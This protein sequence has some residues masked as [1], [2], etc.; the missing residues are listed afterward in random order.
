M[1]NF[2]CLTYQTHYQGFVISVYPWGDE[3]IFYAK[4]GDG[5]VKHEGAP[6]K[7]YDTVDGA[8]NV[9]KD[10]IDFIYGDVDCYQ[11]RPLGAQDASAT[12]LIPQ[13][14]AVTVRLSYL[15]EPRAI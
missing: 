3:Q 2:T 14:M 12:S 4:F 6:A 10:L 8:V 11:E 5:D 9:C 1:I 13:S 7:L 15:A